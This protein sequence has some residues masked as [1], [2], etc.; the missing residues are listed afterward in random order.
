MTK[1]KRMARRK[2]RRTTRRK[3]RKLTRRKPS[4]HSSVVGSRLPGAIV[5]ASSSRSLPA[6]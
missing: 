4:L 5:L 3:K 2:R 6:S 1:T